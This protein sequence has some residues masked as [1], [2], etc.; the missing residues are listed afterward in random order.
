[1]R[2]LIP[3]AILH[4]FHGGHLGLVTE[5]AEVAPMISQFLTAAEPVRQAAPARTRR[6]S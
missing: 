5:A 4:V 6:G 2:R 3:D 1:M